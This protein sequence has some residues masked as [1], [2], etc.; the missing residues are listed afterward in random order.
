MSGIVLAAYREF[1]SREQLLAESGLSKPKR[2]R[3]VIKAAL[4]KITRTEIMEKCPNISSVTVERALNKLVKSGK[5]L[6]IGG[7]RYTAYAW[8]REDE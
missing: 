2:V 1:S 5:V 4:G 3:E 6:K 7:G 8:N